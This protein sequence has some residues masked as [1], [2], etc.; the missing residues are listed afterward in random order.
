MEVKYTKSLLALPDS[1]T[2]FLG[3]GPIPIKSDKCERNQDEER[4]L[5]WPEPPL[6]PGP[7]F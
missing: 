5:A 6:D 1:G 7:Y 4:F 2:D 3:G